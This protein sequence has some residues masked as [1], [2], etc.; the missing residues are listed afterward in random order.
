MRKKEHEKYVSQTTAIITSREIDF[1]PFFC[2]GASLTHFLLLFE[3]HSWK[4]SEDIFQTFF[5]NIFICLKMFDEIVLI[6]QF[7]G[8]FFVFFKTLII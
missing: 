2:G 3:L 1:C 8:V 7:L 4:V 5:E 6:S